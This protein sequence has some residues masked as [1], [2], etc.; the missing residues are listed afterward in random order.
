MYTPIRNALSHR[1]HAEAYTVRLLCLW[2]RALYAART[3][4]SAT[5]CSNWCTPVCPLS[6]WHV[7]SNRLRL[8]AVT[9]ASRPPP[10]ACAT[11]RRICRFCAIARPAICCAALNDHCQHAFCVK[12]PRLIMRLEGAF[13]GCCLRLLMS[14]VCAACQIFDLQRAACLGDLCWSAFAAESGLVCQDCEALRR[15]RSGG[16]FG[17]ERC[18]TL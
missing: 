9:V 15:A 7:E 5:K 4:T 13:A 3:T 12:A 1:E 2:R 17:L 8:P 18:A 11:G 16:W 14:L 6:H 10:L